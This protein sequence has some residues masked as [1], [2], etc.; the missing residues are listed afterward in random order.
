MKFEA[1]IIIEDIHNL[2]LPL[3]VQIQTLNTTIFL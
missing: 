2:L 3:L 1:K